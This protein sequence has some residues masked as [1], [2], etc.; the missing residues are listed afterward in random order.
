[1]AASD[2]LLAD[3]SLEGEDAPSHDPPQQEHQ[4]QQQG[5]SAKHS[6]ISPHGKTSVP[7]SSR[8]PTDQP[9]PKASSTTNSSGSKDDMDTAD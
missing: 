5:L 6:P 4:P 7:Q 3:L 8:A 2:D 9:R 1:M